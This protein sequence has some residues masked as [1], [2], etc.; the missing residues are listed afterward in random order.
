MRTT[1]T[2]ADDVAAAVEQ[3]RRQDDVGVSEAVNRLVRRGLVA[4]AAKRMPFRQSTAH[5]GL[6]VDVTNVAEALEQLD[7][8]RAT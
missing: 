4:P 2:L 3:L 5:I 1:L 6:T 8:P 7:G